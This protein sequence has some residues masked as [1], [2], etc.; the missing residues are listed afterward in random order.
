MKVGEASPSQI[1]AAASAQPWSPDSGSPREPVA[2]TGITDRADELFGKIIESTP[3]RPR[4][5]YLV[6]EADAGSVA[7][8]TTN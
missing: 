5:Y 1:Q 2:V 7:C 3:S 6:Q 8:S 4:R